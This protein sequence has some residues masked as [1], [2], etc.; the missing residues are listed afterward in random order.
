M[1]DFLGIFNL[2]LNKKR[3]S[4]CNQNIYLK[5]AVTIERRKNF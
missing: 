3:N 2:F 1:S 5:G 4:N